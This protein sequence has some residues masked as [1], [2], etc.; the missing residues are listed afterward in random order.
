MELLTV[1]VAYMVE[2]V[3]AKK[4]AEAEEEVEEGRKQGRQEGGTEG[5]HTTSSLTVGA[6]FAQA[7]LHC[8]K[9]RL[10]LICRYCMR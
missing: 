2:P 9:G 8:C 3:H 6:N 7:F 1:L 4:I 10:M 5:N